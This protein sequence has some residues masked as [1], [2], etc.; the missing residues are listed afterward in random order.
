[1]SAYVYIVHCWL[2]VSKNRLIDIV[3]LGCGDGIGGGGGGDKGNVWIVP[4][5]K[6]LVL[7]FRARQP[8]LTVQ[9]PVAKSQFLLTGYWSGTRLVG[10]AVH[11]CTGAADDEVWSSCELWGWLEEHL[12]EHHQVW[13]LHCSWGTHLFTCLCQGWELSKTKLTAR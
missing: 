9:S 11:E 7:Y 2:P 5:V 1:M 4:F 10:W 13:L 6:Y 12:E 8:R 3:Q